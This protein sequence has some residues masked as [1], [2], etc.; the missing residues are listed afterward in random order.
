VNLHGWGACC[1]EPK[2]T[3]VLFAVHD[4]N[5]WVRRCPFE[6]E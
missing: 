3:Q 1:E 5:V 2:G 6:V 4:A